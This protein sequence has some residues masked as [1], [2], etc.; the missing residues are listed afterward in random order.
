MELGAGPRPVPQKQLD[1]D[2]LAAALEVVRN[3]EVIARARKVELAMRTEGG[4]AK[5]AD[6]IGAFLG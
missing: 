6:V 4:A 5:A 3:H 1:S 2:G